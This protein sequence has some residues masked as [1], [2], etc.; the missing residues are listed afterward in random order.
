[1]R[2]LFI[3]SDVNVKGG[4]K[5]YHFGLGILSAVLKE[6]GHETSLYYMYDKFDTAPLMEKINDFKPSLIAATSDSSQF[7]YIQR[8]FKEVMPFGVFTI[9]GGPHVSLY[10]R[11]LEETDGLSAICIGEGEG[12]ILELVDALENGKDYREIK[13]LWI[14]SDGN[15]I[16]NMQR[17][18][19]E[20]L[21]SLPFCDREVFNYQSVIDSDYDRAV[22]MLSRGCPYR[23]TYCSNHAL[24]VLQEGRYVRF[25]GVENA[26]AEIKSVLSRYS[27]KSIFLAD[28][29]F[30][31]K[32]DFVKEFCERYKKEIGLPF[33]VTTRVE[34]ASEDMFQWLKDAGCIRVAMGIE[35]GN[36]WLREKILNRKMSNEQIIMAFRL[37]R[38]AGLKTKSYNIVGFPN[39]TEEMFE[40]TVKLNAEVSPDSH[41]CYI[42]NPYP[43]TSLYEYCKEKGFFNENLKDEFVSRTDTPLNLPTFS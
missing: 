43:G 23:C 41:V 36:E 6:K 3:Y 40:D 42:F 26:I 2:I 9:C 21:D 22:F 5:S 35:S 28:D 4:A 7:R 37:A 30:T 27:A 12:A 17:P 11:A 20:D 18:F 10:P 24:R 39:E 25:R 32:R 19:V 16:R 15:V 34:S 8:I 38:E 1:M 13:N 29:V 33:E 31:L 14:K